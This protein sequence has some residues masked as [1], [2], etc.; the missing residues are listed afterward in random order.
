M[1]RVLKRRLLSAWNEVEHVRYRYRSPALLLH[2]RC[3]ET[4]C[5]LLRLR[6]Q[7]NFLAALQQHLS[8]D[9]FDSTALRA[10]D[11]VKQGKRPPR[12]NAHVFAILLCV[13]L[14]APLIALDWTIHLFNEA[15][16][17][18]GAELFFLGAPAV[19][20]SSIAVLILLR[21]FVVAVHSMRKEQRD[22]SV[23][24]T[25]RQRQLMQP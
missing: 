15:L 24:D 25:D 7:Q 23:R 8:P 14:G 13:Y 20:I 16:E 10:I 12:P 9:Q 21:W 3:G 17:A 4:A 1:A 2:L 22:A 5:N 11:S 6:G 19:A 18:Q